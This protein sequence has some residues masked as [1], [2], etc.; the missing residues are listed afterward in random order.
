M[1]ATRLDM[2]DTLLKTKGTT[3]RP[4]IR[5]RVVFIPRRVIDCGLCIDAC[6]VEAIFPD[7][8]VPEKWTAFIARNYEQF[9][10]TPP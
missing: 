9:G 6:P 7:D 5:I 3:R 4:A 1:V 2:A 10:L 8:E